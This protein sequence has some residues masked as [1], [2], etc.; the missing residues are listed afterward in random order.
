MHDS[1]R[2]HAWTSTAVRQ[3]RARRLGSRWHLK[4]ARRWPT[5]FLL[6]I[7]AALLGEGARTED[8]NFCAELSAV[9]NHRSTVTFR[10]TTPASP[11]F[12]PHNKPL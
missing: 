12:H 10:G 8:W 6:S 2:T 1:P 5:L 3:P 11:E 4:R 9:L 7:S